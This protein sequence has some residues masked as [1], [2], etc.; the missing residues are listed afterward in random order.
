MRIEALGLC[1]PSEALNFIL[2]ISPV[3]SGLRDHL[4]QSLV[5]DTGRD[6][7]ISLYVSWCHSPMEMISLCPLVMAHPD[8]IPANGIATK[9]I[10]ENGLSYLKKK[11]CL[12][13]RP[14]LLHTTGDFASML[15]L[16]LQM[17]LVRSGCARTST[18]VSNSTVKVVNERAG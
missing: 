14:S 10:Y 11:D 16:I 5:K 17:E 18:Y 3:F 6:L 8:V 7:F 15:W 2:L 1:P 4:K 12:Q 9:E 13:L